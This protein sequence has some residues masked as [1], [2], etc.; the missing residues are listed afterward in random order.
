MNKKIMV[1]IYD[2]SDFLKDNLEDITG[3]DVR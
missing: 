1:S 3:W 2:L